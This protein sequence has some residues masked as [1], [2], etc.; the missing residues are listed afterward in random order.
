M[1]DYNKIVKP[2]VVVNCITHQ[3]ADLLLRWAFEQGLKWFD[4]KCYI[5]NTKWEIYDYETC[6]NLYEGSAGSRRYYAKKQFKILSYEEA[7]KTKEK[8]S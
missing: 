1:F 7:L 8:I 2:N 4:N 3:Q 6:Y 5:N